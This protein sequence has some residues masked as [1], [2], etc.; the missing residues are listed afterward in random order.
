VV[1]EYLLIRSSLHT[2]GENIWG[3]GALFILVVRISGDYEL[4]SNWW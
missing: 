2:G 3:F 1:R 4:S